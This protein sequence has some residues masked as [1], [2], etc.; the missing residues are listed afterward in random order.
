MSVLVRVS[1]DI[2]MSRFDESTIRQ[3]SKINLAHLI[4]SFR[5]ADATEEDETLDI[6]IV[7]RLFLPRRIMTLLVGGLHTPPT[8]VSVGPV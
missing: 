4:A 5:E 1:V 7:M 6:S 2:N 3:M 8:P